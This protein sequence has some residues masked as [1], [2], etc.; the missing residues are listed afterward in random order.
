MNAFAFA[1]RS[2]IIARFIPARQYCREVF[3][4]SFPQRVLDY[5]P[6][7][8]AAAFDD[9]GRHFFYIQPLNHINGTLELVAYALLLLGYRIVGGIVLFIGFVGFVTC[10]VCCPFFLMVACFCGILG[11]ASLLCLGKCSFDRL[12]C[13]R[14]FFWN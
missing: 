6:D 14:F 8:F 10:F 3:F 5:A 13:I 12:G 11:V 4:H 1:I 9:D 7:L 2:M